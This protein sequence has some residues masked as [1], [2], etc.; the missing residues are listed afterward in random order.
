[1]TNDVSAVVLGRYPA[2]PHHLMGIEGILRNAHGIGH[3]T[4]AIVR[5]ATMMGIGIAE[6]DLHTTRAHA[7]ACAGTLQPVLMPAL[8][9]AASQCVHVVIIVECWCSAI[10]RAVALLVIGV[11]VLVPVFAK[12]F[13]AIVLHRPHGLRGTLVDVEHLAAIFGLGTVE[14]LT[15]TDGTSAKGVILVANLLHLL[16][17]LFRDAEVA[18]LVENDGG[19]VTVIDNGIAHELGTLLPAR[20]FHVLLGI[21]CRHG[22]DESHA[23]A[24]L[25]VLLPGAN[26]HPAHQVAT[27]FHNE[28]VRVIA[29]P[30]RDADAYAGP[31]VGSA[32]SI[33][34]HHH[35]AVVQVELA[36][37]EFCFTEACTSGNLVELVFL[38]WW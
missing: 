19:V 10:E 35:A 16:H 8:H 22:L 1:M 23:V 4:G 36:V 17:V 20:S 13:I 7:L 9:H 18:T 29:Q 5:F 25:N 28:V 32:L 2:V 37:F 27:T 24:R 15:R 38:A 31:F 6:H 14:H 12:S 11:G 33:A 3:A 26:V 30:G 21:A 34:M